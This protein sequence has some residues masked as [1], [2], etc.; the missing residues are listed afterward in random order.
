MDS[1]WVLDY[2]NMLRL[3][4]TGTV[5]DASWTQY[6]DS[7]TTLIIAS[8]VSGIEGNL[9]STLPNLNQVI[10]EGDKPTLAPNAFSGASVNAYYSHSNMSWSEE[11]LLNYG[12]SVAWQVYCTHSGA[13]LD[14][15]EAVHYNEIPVADC[16]TDGCKEHWKCSVCGLAFSDETLTKILTDEKRIIPAPGHSL[17][18]VKGCAAT[19]TETG[20]SDKIFCEV[21]NETIQEQEEIPMLPHTDIVYTAAV[22][23]TCSTVGHTEGHRCAVCGEILIAS[24][25]LEKLPHTDVISLEALEP[26]C[27]EEG[28]TERHICEVCGEI[29]TESEAIPALGH[30][31]EEPIYIWT[32][33]NSSV[34][35]RRICDRNA[36]HSYEK[37]VAVRCIVTVPPTQTTEGE[38]KYVSVSFDYEAFEVQE[39]AGDMIPALDALDVLTL[40]GDVTEIKDEAFMNLTCQAVIIRDGCISIGNKAFMNC[41]D[42]MY[43]RIPESIKSFPSDAF[44]GCPNII[45]DWAGY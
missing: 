5:T 2:V 18:L 29:L 13:S 27:T 21:C 35:A 41:K 6:A 19:C 24:R 22:E 16:T 38:W 37:T 1:T 36:E 12:G 40:P 45:I 44:A 10:F 31:W 30:D 34:T 20:L 4:G 33:D 11:D 14:L 3:L 42:L 25:E 23:P 9:L 39:K 43:I 7:V 26:D 17:V 32:E 28:H 15:Y 8:D